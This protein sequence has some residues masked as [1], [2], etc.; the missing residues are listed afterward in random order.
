MSS[1]FIKLVLRIF[2]TPTGALEQGHSSLVQPFTVGVAGHPSKSFCLYK[3]KTPKQSELRRRLDFNSGLF[4]V[5][6]LM[7]VNL[8]RFGIYVTLISDRG[9]SISLFVLGMFGRTHSGTTD[10]IKLCNR[11]MVDLSL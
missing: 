2:K 11:S 8:L 6:R 5:I 9:V 7:R 10:I 3:H 4:K 1:L